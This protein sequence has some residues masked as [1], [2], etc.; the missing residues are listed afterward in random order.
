MTERLE[1][2]IFFK[3]NKKVY[4]SNI[5][6]LAPVFKYRDALSH[7]LQES[8][9]DK[10]QPS[11][12]DFHPVLRSKVLPW[13]ASVYQGMWPAPGQQLCGGRELMKKGKQ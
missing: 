4:S 13:L 5:R 12:S 9:A 3:K 7:S 2:M 10:S 1:K 6:N 8:R 11:V